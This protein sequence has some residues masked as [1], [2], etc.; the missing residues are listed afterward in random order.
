MCFLAT[1]Y[2][3]NLSLSELLSLSQ[4]K[5]SILIYVPT[6]STPVNKFRDLTI[7]FLESFTPSPM[8]IMLILI[9]KAL[10]YEMTNANENFD[11]HFIHFS[12]LGKWE[13]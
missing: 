10:A 5:L 3:N 2:Q 4:I 1:D 9:N 13:F 7:S 11:V 6:L 12:P 8:L